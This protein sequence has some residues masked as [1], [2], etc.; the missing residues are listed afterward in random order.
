MVQD[1]LSA[2]VILVLTSKSSKF[3]ALTC[4]KNQARGTHVAFRRLDWTEIVKF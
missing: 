1:E 3:L 2:H 4:K